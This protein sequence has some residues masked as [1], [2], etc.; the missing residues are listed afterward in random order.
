[1]KGR[2]ARLYFSFSLFLSLLLAFCLLESC[3]SVADSAGEESAPLA[4]GEAGEE[5]SAD[6]TDEISLGDEE[7]EDDDDDDDDDAD[8]NE[9]VDLSSLF[10]SFGGGAG[11]GGGLDNLQGLSGLFDNLGSAGGSGD[12]NLGNLANLLPALGKIGNASGEEKED[13]AEL[14]NKAAAQQN[15]GTN[16]V[17]PDFVNQIF[18]MISKNNTALNDIMTEFMQDPYMDVKEIER[19]TIDPQVFANAPPDTAVSTNKD[20]EAAESSTA[21]TPK[22]PAATGPPEIV[23]SKIKDF[24]K[25]PGDSEAEGAATADPFAE[26]NEDGAVCRLLVLS[27][28]GAR[29]AFQAGAVVGLAEQY[30]AQGREL[31]WDVVAGVGFGGVQAAF[32]LPFKPGQN[33]ELDY[34]QSLWR[35]WQGLKEED[36]MRCENGMK[37]LMDI[38]ATMKWIQKSQKYATNVAKMLKVPL[39]HSCDTARLAATLRSQ[40]SQLAK[41]EVSGDASDADEPRVAVLTASK[42]GGGRHSWTLRP[43]HLET[44]QCKTGDAGSV[45]TETQESPED[46]AAAE[47]RTPLMLALEG[48]TAIPGTFPPIPFKNATGKLEGLIDGAVNTFLNVLPGLSACQDRVRRSPKNPFSDEEI[49]GGKGV[50]VDFILSVEADKPNTEGTMTDEDSEADDLFDNTGVPLENIAL[51]KEKFPAL[52]IRHV[53]APEESY[54]LAHDLMDLRSIRALLELGRVAGWGAQLF[55]PVKEDSA[56]DES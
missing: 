3:V 9:N 25:K 18:S 50:S 19:P 11:L 8:E 40:I 31:K 1:M 51:L 30:K 52:T 26:T 13:F 34:G 23:L 17:S 21:E 5:A 44:D 56:S 54:E 22:T 27:G 29:S 16:Q 41:K 2:R 32:G 4:S 24:V 47:S 12:P 36:F 35:F 38:R 43:S 53:L 20:G 33:G 15:S 6:E 46:A 7:D 45:C 28:G 39:P 55:E 14:L 48:T 49:A 37:D 10:G 42:L